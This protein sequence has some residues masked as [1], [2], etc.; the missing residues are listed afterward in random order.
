MLQINTLKTPSLT[1]GKCHRELDEI[2][3]E[4]NRL[5]RDTFVRE[6]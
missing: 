1:Q 4:L 5:D 2:R 6:Q 3:E